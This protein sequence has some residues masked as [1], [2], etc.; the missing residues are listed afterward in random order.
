MT[1]AQSSDESGVDGRLARHGKLSYMQIPARDPVALGAF[2]ASVFGWSVSGRPAHV[3]FRDASG[4]LTGAFV[5][6]LTPASEPGIL[7]YVYVD[8][9]DAIIERITSHGG[10]VVRT[11]YPEGALRVATFRDPDGNVIGLWQGGRGNVAGSAS[12]AARDDG[13]RRGFAGSPDRRTRMS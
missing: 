1:R 12:T 7:P 4:E 13:R 3:N 8:G 9:I 2:Y 5:T 6:N 10:A 11:P